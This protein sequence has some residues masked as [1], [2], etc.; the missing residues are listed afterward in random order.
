MKNKKIYHLILIAFSIAL[1]LS[2]TAH[3]GVLNSEPQDAPYPKKV[4]AQRGINYWGY[5]IS[6]KVVVDIDKTF[7]DLGLSPAVCGFQA[8]DQN[9]HYYHQLGQCFFN[10]YLQYRNDTSEK[11][12]VY[13]WLKDQSEKN[14]SSKPMK[15]VWNRPDQPLWTTVKQYLQ[16]KFEDTFLDSDKPVSMNF[17]AGSF[18]LYFPNEDVFQEILKTSSLSQKLGPFANVTELLQATH[19]GLVNSGNR[20]ENNYM[21]Y[22]GQLSLQLRSQDLIDIDLETDINLAKQQRPFYIHGKTQWESQQ[23]NV[24]EKPMRKP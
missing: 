18:S 17:I 14:I 16:M 20:S 9:I 19:F 8:K 3:A 15:I 11:I 1:V 7:S 5:F 12:I 10:A 23:P 21:I 2:Q 24:T 13:S 4:W 6:K 22:Q